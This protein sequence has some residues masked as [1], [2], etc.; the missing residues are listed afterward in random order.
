M[1]GGG[2]LPPGMFFETR[3]EKTMENAIAR[4]LIA[5]VI[6]SVALPG[7]APRAESGATVTTIPEAQVRER[8]SFGGALPITDLDS[9]RGGTEINIMDI[10]S[11]GLVSDNVANDLTTGNNYI[12]ESSFSGASGFPT[13][14]Q[15]SGN[16]VLIQNS[17]NINLHVQ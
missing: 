1:P 11:D 4:L 5:G 16:N 7:G 10:T 17:T 12:S 6:L 8:F 9:Y 3:K 14:I 13:V 2:F 15:N